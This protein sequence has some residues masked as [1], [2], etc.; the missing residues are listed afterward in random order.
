VKSSKEV[1]SDSAQRLIDLY[2]CQ[3]INIHGE[4]E[5]PW[6]RKAV[7]DI[8]ELMSELS[9]PDGGLE[10][11]NRKEY[12]T[13]EDLLTMIST[14]DPEGPQGLVRREFL[15]KTP[16]Q[17]ISTKFITTH[18]GFIF[19]KDYVK[20]YL[21]YGL[22]FPDSWNL[23][24]TSL[25]YD[26]VSIRE[27]RLKEAVELT[28]LKDELPQ[29]KERVK[30]LKWKLDKIKEYAFTYSRKE[31]IMRDPWEVNISRRFVNYG[32]KVADLQSKLDQTALASVGNYHQPCIK[33]MQNGVLTINENKKSDYLKLT[34]LYRSNL[35]LDSN[36]EDGNCKNIK[37]LSNFF[38]FSTEHEC[39]FLSRYN[40][41]NSDLGSRCGF[42]KMILALKGENVAQSVIEQFLY[43]FAP[44]QLFKDTV[45]VAV[46]SSIPEK[47]SGCRILVKQIKELCGGQ[48]LS[49]LLKRIKRVQK[50]SMGGERGGVSELK[51]L[52]LHEP[53]RFNQKNI[54]LIDDIVT[55]GGTMKICEN[56]LKAHS[57]PSS[58]LRFALG[59]TK[60]NY[61]GRNRIIQPSYARDTVR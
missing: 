45:L 56:V 54:I 7:L 1:N 17:R 52:A 30:L 49:G 35:F 27:C 37:Q 40:P 16:I 33:K 29:F 34:E 41:V 19:K 36:S 39:F 9:C 8:V 43:F 50:K 6:I 28:K 11:Y 44:I 60:S 32:L 58:I 51:S 26:K 48:V 2:A 15:S 57:S 14:W 53:H 47:V 3:V 24:L 5:S 22:K 61:P 31:K 12:Q 46:P 42:S 25:F 59:K 38:H 20:E 21:R 18:K 55:T 10:W 4:K 13:I 23:F